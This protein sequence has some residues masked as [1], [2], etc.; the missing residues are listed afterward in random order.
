MGKPVL[1]LRKETER[2]EAIAAGT[3]KLAGVETDD[4]LRL[5]REL[6]EDKEIYDSMAKAVNPYGDG[7]ACGRIADAISWYFGHCQERPVDFKG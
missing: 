2:P 7:E 5:V 6:L 3:A 1:V 4:I